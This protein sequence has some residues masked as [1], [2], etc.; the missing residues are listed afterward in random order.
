MIYLTVLLTLLSPVFQKKAPS[1]ELVSS[2]EVV[3]KYCED[4]KEDLLKNMKLRYK[5]LKSHRFGYF[6]KH[7]EKEE[8]TLRKQ[9]KLVNS[10]EFLPVPGVLGFPV[11]EEGEVGRLPAYQAEV[12]HVLE[13]NKIIAR[14]I[15]DVSQISDKRI[16]KSGK[17]QHDSRNGTVRASVLITNIETESLLEGLVIDVSGYFIAEE[18][19]SETSDK[20][21]VYRV[22]TNNEMKK[23]LKVK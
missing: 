7:Y 22:I 20:K 21:P 15:V 8:N 9:I 14:L 13:D 23:A 4:N 5:Y 2:V 1:L 11:S 17:F 18:L 3:R 10:K 16:L 6:R 19:S 12:E